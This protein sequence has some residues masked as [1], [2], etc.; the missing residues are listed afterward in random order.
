M[1]ARRATLAKPSLFDFDAFIRTLPS[2]YQFGRVRRQKLLWFAYWELFVSHDEA[3]FEATFIRQKYGPVETSMDANY[4]RTGDPSKLGND[5]RAEVKAILGP[6]LEMPTGELVDQS[7]RSPA[8]CS[9]EPKTEITGDDQRRAKTDHLL[10][11]AMWHL[12]DKPFAAVL[13]NYALSFGRK[14][15]KRHF[16]LSVRQLADYFGWDKKTLC[17]AIA[18]LHERGFF[19]LIRKGKGPF[20][21]EYAVL[22][23]K[24]WSQANPKKCRTTV[25]SNG[26][27]VFY[28]RQRE[29][30]QL[31][32]GSF[33]SG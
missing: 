3:P 22:T 23:H 10:C 13:Y 26:Y 31:A 16:Y 30:G 32:L 12:R 27:S 1:T 4:G 24:E 19:E 25:P 18:V 29:R 7:H 33:K 2:S 21:S 6:L 9:G 11:T 5:V 15:G 17:P 14:N 28:S 20:A 8:Y